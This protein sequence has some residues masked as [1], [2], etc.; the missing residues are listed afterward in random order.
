MTG[1]NAKRVDLRLLDVRGHELHAALF[2]NVQEEF[3]TT[4]STAHYSAGM[5]MLLMKVDG[6]TITKK[7][8]INR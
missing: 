1:I 4:I 7:V 8:L 2:R 6:R 5:Y 3:N